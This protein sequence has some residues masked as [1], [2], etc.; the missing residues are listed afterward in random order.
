MAFSSYLLICLVFV[1]SIEAAVR[2][3]NLADYILYA[4]S[5][6]FGYSP[7]PGASGRMRNR[8]RWR[9]N[10]RGE[11]SDIDSA[12]EKSS[13]VLVGDSVV[14]GGSFIDQSET[15]ANRIIEA[16]CRTVH[17]VAAS[18]WTLPNELSFVLAN[19]HLF[20]AET[21]VFV[22]NGNDLM[23]INDR[24]SRIT[25][26]TDRPAFQTAFLVRRYLGAI[27]HGVRARIRA[28]S[29]AVLPG[30]DPDA[31]WQVPLARFLGRFDGRL[32]WVLYPSRT[33]LRDRTAPCAKLKG[34]IT[35]RAEIIDLSEVPDWTLACYLDELHPNGHGRRVLA[36]ALSRAILRQGQADR[37]AS[38]G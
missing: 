13:V 20:A 7:N 16:T 4:R 30:P 18:G 36:E 11:R 29:R 28:D 14:E 32:I 27:W 17:P 35:E 10:P 12:I 22:S 23:R 31:V 15:L 24:V 1:L 9:I 34:Q 5:D 38:G 3:F 21:F 19:E 8:Y 25:H 2:V 6:A 26:P 33:E 37:L